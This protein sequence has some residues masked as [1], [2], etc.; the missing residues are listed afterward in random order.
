MLGR[1]G[2]TGEETGGG[3]GGGDKGG[4]GPKAGGSMGNG[5]RY[6]GPMWEEGGN[7]AMYGSA[8]AVL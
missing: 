2:E 3:R 6:M 5:G 7:E 8:E 1:G 4:V